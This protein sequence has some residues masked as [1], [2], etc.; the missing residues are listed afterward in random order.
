MQEQTKDQRCE[1]AIYWD[2][3]AA[4]AGDN[5]TWNDLRIQEQHAVMTS[6]N[7]ILQVLNIQKKD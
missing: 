4:K 2:A 3:L 7:M 5:R 1:V 6:I